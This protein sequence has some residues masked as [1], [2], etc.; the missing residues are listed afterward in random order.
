MTGTSVAS[1][2]T[3]PTD[4]RQVEGLF[5]T[6]GQIEQV[7][8]PAPPSSTG[9]AARQL[10]PDCFYQIGNLIYLNCNTDY[11]YRMVYYAGIPSLSIGSPT[12]WLILRNPNV[13][14]YATLL[15]LA[16][17]LQ[18]DDRINVW[19]AG[20]QNAV[21]ALQRQD[22]HIRFGPSPRMRVDFNAA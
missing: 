14:L 4:F 7:L 3:P 22:D 19:G 1:V 11:S 17:Y 5:I 12:N 8:H 2:I 13:Y 9:N 20:Y 10:I 21:A 16:P 6:I 18:D 15:E